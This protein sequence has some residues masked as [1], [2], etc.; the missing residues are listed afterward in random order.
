MNNNDQIPKKKHF[1]NCLANT[2]LYNTRSVNTPA[3][4]IKQYRDV[5]KHNNVM[6]NNIK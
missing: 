5:Q 6:H 3:K 2:N 4:I 1:V